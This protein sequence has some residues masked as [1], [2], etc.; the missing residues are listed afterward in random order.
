MGGSQSHDVKKVEKFD[1]TTSGKELCYLRK[2][3]DGGTGTRIKVKI[4]KTKNIKARD[5][6]HS[7]MD[8][9]GQMIIVCYNKCDDKSV[10]LETTLKREY[11][12]RFVKRK[13]GK[14]SEV[15]IL[16]THEYYALLNRFLELENYVFNNEEVERFRR[17]ETENNCS[18]M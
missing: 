9:Q 17:R 4:G 16:N 14:N 18:M 5:D 2:C 15:L 7:T 6:Q 10:T 13:S 8:P 11:R 3:G 1:I 12:G